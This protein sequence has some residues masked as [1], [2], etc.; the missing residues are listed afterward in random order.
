MYT[1]SYLN[2]YDALSEQ[3]NS[4][5]NTWVYLVLFKFPQAL[6]H[7]DDVQ[8]QFD[9]DDEQQLEQDQDDDADFHLQVVR[10]EKAE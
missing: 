7:D 9:A 1:C 3:V 8:Q 10:R 2:D 4:S 6:Q 5:E